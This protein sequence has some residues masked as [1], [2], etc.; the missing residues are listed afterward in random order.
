LMA[1][2]AVAV[3]VSVRG[4]VVPGARWWFD[5]AMPLTVVG[6]PSG[7]SRVITRGMRAREVRPLQGTGVVF[8]WGGH[9]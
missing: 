9:Y 6:G 1:L 8:A 5:H 4:S 7:A 3:C 2:P